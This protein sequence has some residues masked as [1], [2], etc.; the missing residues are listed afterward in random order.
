MDDLLGLVPTRADIARDYPNKW[1]W[2]QLKQFVDS[3]DLGLLKRHPRLQVVCDQWYD[4]VRARHGSL[5]AYLVNVRLGWGNLPPPPRGE[6][7]SASSA[8]DLWKILPNDW[9]YSVPPEIEHAL[10]W[11]RL[12]I[13]DPS[14][15]PPH[16]RPR[17][18]VCGIWGFTGGAHLELL[19]APPLGPEAQA[20]VDKWLGT[21]DEAAEVREAVRVAGEEVG[22]FVRAHWPEDE[23]ETAW[24]VNPPRLQSIP[25]LAHAHVFA[26]R[27]GVTPTD[28]APEPE[29]AS[30]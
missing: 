9:P 29:P 6:F 23:W 26:K 8:G 24:F 16:I 13:I 2:L 25:G 5:P 1:S 4:V 14:R 3:G 28:P 11:T 15:V 27:Q 17:I 12:P 22:A 20:R 7:F 10:V 30:S 19:Q 21:G 18:D